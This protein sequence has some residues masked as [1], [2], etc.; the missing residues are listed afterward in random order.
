MVTR[1]NNCEHWSSLNSMII[2]LNAV[3]CKSPQTEINISGKVFVT[4]IAGAVTS[5][6]SETTPVSPVLNR[7]PITSTHVATTI[8]ETR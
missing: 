4:T 1:N 6:S 2:V 7:Q 3:I 8:P 5:A